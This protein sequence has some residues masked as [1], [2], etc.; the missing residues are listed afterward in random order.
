MFS[1]GVTTIPSLSPKVI[2]LL[3]TTWSLGHDFLHDGMMQIAASANARNNNFF[4]L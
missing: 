4:I 1:Y 3:D 2:G